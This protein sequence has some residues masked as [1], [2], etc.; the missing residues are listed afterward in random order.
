MSGEILMKK[1]RKQTKSI[2]LRNLYSIS[3]L[4]F[5]NIAEESLLLYA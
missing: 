5:S 1:F 2:N 3:K 4:G